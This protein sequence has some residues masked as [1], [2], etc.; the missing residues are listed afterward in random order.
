MMISTC[1]KCGS[2][3]SGADGS[4]PACLLLGALDDPIE[5]PDEDG[6]DAEEDGFEPRR[7]AGYELVRL[8]GVGGTAEVH[9]ARQSEPVD[10]EVALKLIR[11]GLHSARVIARFEAEREVLAKLHSPNIATI[12][13]AGQTRDGLPYFVMEYVEGVPVTQFAAREGLPLERRLRLFGQICDA[14][15][16]AHQRGVVHRDLKPSN[17]LVDASGQVKVIDFGIARAMEE[18]FGER[19]LFMT[20]EGEILGT[21]AYMS[22]EQALGRMAEIDTRSD[23]F[24]LGAI[25]YELLT[26]ALPVDLDRLR[27]TSPMELRQILTETD[28]PRPSLRDTTTR[29]PVGAIRGDLDWIVMKALERDKDRRYATVEALAEDVARHLANEPVSAGPPTVGYRLRKF[30]RRNRAVALGAA[31]AVVALVAGSVFSVAQAMRASEARGEAESQAQAAESNA[32]ASEAARNVSEA[33]NEFL[34]N[35]LLGTDLRNTPN[36]NV[37]LR[38]LVDTAAGKTGERFRGQP[39]VAMEVELRIADLYD[40]LGEFGKAEAMYGRSRESLRSLGDSPERGV[41]EERVLRRLAINAYRQGLYPKMMEYWEEWEALAARIELPTDKQLQA[42][43]E[44]ANTLAATDRQDEG[45]ERMRALLPEV[46]KHFGPEGNQT[47]ALKLNLGRALTHMGDLAAGVPLLED[48]VQGTRRVVGETLSLSE[49]LAHLGVTYA[50]QGRIGESTKAFDEAMAIQGKI[51]RPGHLSWV[52]TRL[53]LASSYVATGRGHLAEPI[54]LELFKAGLDSGRPLPHEVLV[55]GQRYGTSIVRSSPA[56]ARPV[57]EKV[58]E[59]LEALGLDREPNCY[60]TRFQLAITYWL[61]GERDEAVSRL[62]DLVDLVI[63][64]S[65]EASPYVQGLRKVLV[66]LELE[67]GQRE[68]ALPYAR[69]ACSAP[70]P[71]EPRVREEARAAIESVLG[72][73]EIAFEDRPK[74]LIELYRDAVAIGLAGAEAW[75]GLG[76]ALH[77]S[78]KSSAD[79]RDLRLAAICLLRAGNV[80]DLAGVKIITEWIRQDEGAKGLRASSLLVGPDSVW[81][82]QEATPSDS[83][84]HQVGFDDSA[85]PSG[86]GEFGY[87]DGDEVTEIGFGDD[88]ENKPMSACF[89]LELT[90]GETY[91]APL[92]GTIAHDDGAVVYLNGEEVYRSLL[93]IGELTPDT[94]AVSDVVFEAP[95][96]GFAIPPRHFTPGHPVVIAVQVHQTAFDTSDLSFA[97]SLAEPLPP[98]E[99]ALAAIPKSELD[100]FFGVTVESLNAGPADGK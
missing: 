20:L 10:R 29:I 89:R 82:Y 45:I 38:E 71:T 72:M 2:R 91:A 62:N 94:P 83:G 46:E 23:V 14:A 69:A 6:G 98:F 54:Y 5:P 37:T 51:L 33:I 84:W 97:F 87:G 4:C 73:V 31:I 13:D 66:S 85:W 47:L 61:T 81:R 75:R 25:L 52:A 55:A 58:L 95:P 9:L 96:H 24:S 44:R 60:E 15:T 88:P 100:A 41:S 28:I 40:A 50:K 32:L 92:V 76:I 27:G 86:R 59:G 67:R 21:P 57:F 16:H 49:A 36:M 56:E 99:Q 30:V 53:S 26:G 77:G 43:A 12:L 34:V 11:P 35:D 90:P 93:P 22:P 3:I 68:A 70:I 74:L 63:A 19:T 8:I 18:E 1:P 39:E 64:R 79:P 7:I 17:V 48:Y 78:Y 80:N 65:G 42:S